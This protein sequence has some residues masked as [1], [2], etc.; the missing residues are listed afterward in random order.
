MV[1]EVRG[2]DRFAEE[3]VTVSYVSGE[4]GIAEVYRG[5]GGGGEGG[6]R[7]EEEEEEKRIHLL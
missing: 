2:R 6:G 1:R 5:R 4:I 3:V 7:E